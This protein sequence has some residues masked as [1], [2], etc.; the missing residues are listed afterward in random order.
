[1]R[2]L[3][4]LCQGKNNSFDAAGES[5]SDFQGQRRQDH[6]NYKGSKRSEPHTSTRV[7]LEKKNLVNY[8]RAL[9]LNEVMSLVRS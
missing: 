9:M 4:R 3:L 8:V 2:V 1:M 6:N 5:R 7:E